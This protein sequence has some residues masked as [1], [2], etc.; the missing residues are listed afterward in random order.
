MNPEV[1]STTTE[2]Y[3]ELIKSLKKMDLR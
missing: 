3:K 1:I 2:E